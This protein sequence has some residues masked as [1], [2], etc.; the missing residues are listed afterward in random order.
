[1]SYCLDFYGVE[2]YLNHG[3]TI[4]MLEQGLVE[5]DKKFLIAAPVEFIRLLVL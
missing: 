2:N 4:S 3:K 1:M 5:N